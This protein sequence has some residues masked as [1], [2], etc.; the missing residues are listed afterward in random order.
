MK[1][2]SRGLGRKE[3]VMDLRRYDLSRDGDD[4]LVSGM[5]T[6]PVNWDFTIRMTPGDIPGMLRVAASRHTLGLGARWALRL[7]AVL[8]RWLLRS[9][10]D[11]EPAPESGA[12]A[13]EEQKV[14]KVAPP[15][16]A[17]AK[18][19]QDRSAYLAEVRR[20]VAASR[21]NGSDQ[22]AGTG[23]DDPSDDARGNAEP[24]TAAPVA[25]ATG[26]N[27]SG[28]AG[29]PA[30]TAAAHVRERAR[31]RRRPSRDDRPANAS[32]APSR[33]AAGAASATGRRPR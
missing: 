1:V 4:M 22:G 10:R 24:V 14:E 13:G 32:R 30:R 31:G 8:V 16:G 11:T 20:Q 12:A 17:A 26:E 7:L 27:G 28:R 29:P 33:T 6:E 25:S 9:G 5:I 18:K 2:K 19:A 23:E 15:V 3:L 21:E